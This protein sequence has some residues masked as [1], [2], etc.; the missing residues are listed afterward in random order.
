MARTWFRSFLRN[1]IQPLRRPRRGIASST[2]ITES[3]IHYLDSAVGNLDKIPLT[4]IPSFPIASYLTQ[5]VYP[6]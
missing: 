3:V 5:L 1:A 6:S 4:E 2:R